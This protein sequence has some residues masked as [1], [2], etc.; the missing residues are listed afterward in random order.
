M[1]AEIGKRYR[2]YKNKEL[3]KVIGIARHSETLEE[4]VIYEALYDSPEFGPHSLW[5]R[6]RGMFEEDVEYEGMQVPRFS[7]EEA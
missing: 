4:F 3:Y 1:K 2:H 6:P 5:A 7:L